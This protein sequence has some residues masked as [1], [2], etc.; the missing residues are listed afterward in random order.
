MDNLAKQIK[1]NILKQ[2]KTNPSHFRQLCAQC[3][4]AVRAIRE[5]L[6]GDQP[7]VD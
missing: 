7:S 2:F 4:M 1:A 5:L 3:D 6:E